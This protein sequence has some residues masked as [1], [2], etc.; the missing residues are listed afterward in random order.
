MSLPLIVVDKLGDF[1]WDDPR[2]VVVT[3]RD[4]IVRA[5]ALK[6]KYE[7]VINL[8][9]TYQYL[10]LGYYCS[11]LAEARRDK[12]IPSVATVL[13]LSSKSIY[14]HALTELDEL[15]QRCMKKEMAQLAFLP[16]LDAPFALHVFF[17]Q[18]GDE[19]FQE[20]ARKTFDLFR[21]PL[22]KLEI[23]RTDKWQIASIRPM[24]L[25]ELKPDQELPF[26]NA[27]DAYT[28]ARWRTPKGPTI[29]EY[30][31]AILYNPQ[32]VLPPSSLR[33]LQKFIKVGESMGVD[34]ELVE[35]KDFLRLAEFDALFIR[36]TTALDH[37][38]YRFAK[39][40]ENEGIPVIDDSNSIQRC[41]N[42]VY[43]AELLKANR[44]P[45]PKTVILDRS[46]LD[47][48][49]RDMAYPVVLK[50]P[51]GSF[52]RGIYRVHSRSELHELAP[53]LFAE[54]DVIIA[55]EYMFTEF[56]WRV[57]VLNRQPLL[58]C[59]YFMS[60]KHWQIVKHGADGRFSEGGCKTLAIGDAPHDVVRIA[61][62]AADLIGN[63]FYGVDLKQTANG[64]F[65]M[66]INDNPSI[67]MGYEDAVLKDDLYRIIIREFTR[68]IEEPQSKRPA[69]QAAAAQAQASPAPV[70]TVPLTMLNGGNGM[71]HPVAA[72]TMA[73]NGPGAVTKVPP[74]IK[75][76]LGPAL[77][78]PIHFEPRAA[79]K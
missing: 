10:S 47:T 34:M 18:I 56:D 66:E 36:E 12:V 78:E 71:G 11:L 16:P 17:G 38:T 65:V 54:S 33:T 50:V 52:S 2:H 46:R 3:A 74:P 25:K 9:R 59:Q 49:E 19:R 23:Q 62:R 76:A 69:A 64:V 40:A 79:G 37:H 14:R 15:L 45:T 41:T 31:V 51:D 29:S 60:R 4:Y 61:T 27:L 32:E 75:P 24:S 28:R 73:A 30:D 35:K 72:N 8:C 44:V 5:D 1:K 20:L 13:D 70:L 68:R 43:L 42:K 7:K 57:C 67:D 77:V 22:L 21:C 63:G 48:L 6:L 53:K 39:K 58:A 26:K 55:Q